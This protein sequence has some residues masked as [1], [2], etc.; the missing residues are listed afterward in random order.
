MSQGHREEWVHYERIAARAVKEKE[1][2]QRK[3]KFE[4][5]HIFDVTIPFWNH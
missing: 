5:F 4:K 3:R 2:T 1:Q